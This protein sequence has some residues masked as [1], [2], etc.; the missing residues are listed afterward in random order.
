[1][2]L[3]ADKKSSAPK[4]REAEESASVI[5]LK[6]DQEH[7]GLSFSLSLTFPSLLSFSLRDLSTRAGLTRIRTIERAIS[8]RCSRIFP[9]N[10]MMIFIRGYRREG[11]ENH[12]SRSHR[13]VKMTERWFAGSALEKKKKRAARL[14]RSRRAAFPERKRKFV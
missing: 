10:R 4:Y 5:R 6:Y 12:P 11:K 2:L 9:C 3:R 14:L 8:F 1:M 13:H 7:S